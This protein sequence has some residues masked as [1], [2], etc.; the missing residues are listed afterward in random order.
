MRQDFFIYLYYIL[1]SHIPTFG[2]CYNDTKNG[3]AKFLEISRRVGRKHRL[4][5][6]YSRGRKMSE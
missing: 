6:S 2:V 4:F 1:Y 3:E 5:Y